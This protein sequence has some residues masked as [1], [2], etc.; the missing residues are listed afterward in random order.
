MKCVSCGEKTEIIDTQKFDTV[1]WR[2]RRC[3]TCDHRVNTHE[4]IVETEQ[5]SRVVIRPEKP[6]IAKRVLV[7]RERPLPVTAAPV[8]AQKK[9]SP[10]TRIEELRAA[11]ER[12]R[13]QD[14]FNEA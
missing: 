7:P 11:L 6:D 3:M 9:I 4:T 5:N 12:K 10:R 8:M 1:V 14:E 2:R 13:M